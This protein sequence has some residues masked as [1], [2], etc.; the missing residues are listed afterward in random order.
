LRKALCRKFKTGIE[1]KT[2]SQ[3]STRLASRPVKSDRA[4]IFLGSFVEE[5]LHMETHGNLEKLTIT[6]LVR[7]QTLEDTA[8]ATVND[9]DISVKSETI[10]LVEA[11]HQFA[12]L[13]D[14][15]PHEHIADFLDICESQTHGKT[16]E[17]KLLLFKFS[18][19]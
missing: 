11:G 5:I 7:K 6:E 9:G 4:E 3:P 14:E 18:L 12:G 1:S 13:T 16:D 2:A 19:K 15:D 17:Y 10:T 8:R